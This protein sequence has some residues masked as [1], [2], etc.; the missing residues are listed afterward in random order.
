MKKGN[1]FYGTYMFM[2]VIRGDNTNKVMPLI[3]SMM[4]LNNSGKFTST[5]GFLV[6]NHLFF[7]KATNQNNVDAFRVH[8]H[9]SI[10]QDVKEN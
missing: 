9:E 1:R 5:L 7:S 4:D 8:I 6:W 2:T 10:H 3:S